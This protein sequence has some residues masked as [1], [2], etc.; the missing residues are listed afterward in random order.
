MG[1]F[2]S[3]GLVVKLVLIVLLYF[4]VVS[5]GIIFYKLLQV[6][7]ANG[8]S[9]RFLEFF[10]KAKRFD[11]IG[12]QLDRFEN[13]PLIVL[14]QEG[15]DELRKLQERGEEKQDPN[16]ISTDLGGIENIARALRRAT[17]SE[18]T[19]LEKYLTFLATTGSTAPFIGLFGT[20]WGIMSAFQN[21]GQ[22]GSASL[23]VVAPGIAEALIATAIGLVAAIP[24]VMGYNHF[25]QRIRVLISEMDSFSTE[26]LNIV[27]RNFAR[28]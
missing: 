17:T 25:Q 22:S 18:I 26:F 6:Y 27:Q 28:R 13:S 11:A 15:Y 16:V 24:A 3:T 7:R 1:M 21:I 8:A 5:W 2:A 19:R 14:F 10:W 9:Q 12:S 23:A 4:S 20:V